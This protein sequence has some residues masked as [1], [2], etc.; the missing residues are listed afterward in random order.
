[1]IKRTLFYLFLGAL[2]LA[3]SCLNREKTFGFTDAQYYIPELDIYISY[4]FKE[5]DKVYRKLHVMISRDSTF[6]NINE[7]DHLVYDHTG[8]WSRE[9]LYISK[10]TNDIYL[11]SIKDVE[12]SKYFVFKDARKYNTGFNCYDFYTSPCYYIQISAEAGRAKLSY[13]LFDK[14][15]F[16]TYKADPII[17]DATL[18][19]GDIIKIDD[20]IEYIDIYGNKQ[21]YDILSQEDKTVALVYDSTY[22]KIKEVAIPSEIMYKDSVYRVKEIGECA[23]IYC[24]SLRNITLP[25]SLNAIGAWVFYSCSSLK[26]INIP[27]GVSKIENHLFSQCSSLTSVNM[28]PNITTIGEKAFFKCISLKS[29]KL[30]NMLDSIGGGAFSF[31]SSLREIK[32]PNTLKNIGIAAFRFCTSLKSLYIPSSVNFIGAY[33]FDDCSGLKRVQFQN[34]IEEQ[35]DTL[36]RLL[37]NTFSDCENL[38]SLEL[39]NHLTYIDEYCFYNCSSLKT[40]TLPLQVDSIGYTAFRDCTSLSKITIPSSVSYIDCCVFSNCTSLRSIILESDN[41]PEIYENALYDRL[42]TRD[43]KVSLIEDRFIIY[44]PDNSLELYKNHALWGQMDIKPMYDL[45]K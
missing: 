42:N 17:P 31:C 9:K 1:M 8:E 37:E 15:E 25:N 43:F 40:I 20:R 39:P 12:N 45:K 2:I 16:R 14:G 34:H 5:D 35:S 19:R 29:I 44:V 3:A 32:F 6:E 27:R 11:Y 41:P 21:Y 22:R 26:N 23:F 7:V 4:S 13:Y 38:E 24:D 33:A 36:L 18:R 28:S 30:P 10:Y